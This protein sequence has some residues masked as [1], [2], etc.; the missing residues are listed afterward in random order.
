MSCPRLSLS[1]PRGG[2]AVR[3]GWEEGPW[4]SAFPSARGLVAGRKPGRGAPRAAGWGGWLGGA[5]RISS[6]WLCVKQ[7]GVKGCS[8]PPRSCPEAV[9][10]R[11]DTRLHGGLGCS[12]VLWLQPWLPFV[13]L[14]S[15]DFPLFPPCLLCLSLGAPGRSRSLLSITSHLSPAHPCASIERGRLCDHRAPVPI[16]HLRPFPAGLGCT[17]QQSRGYFYYRITTC[18]YGAPCCRRA[19]HRGSQRAAVLWG[20]CLA[21]H[22]G[23]STGKG[24]LRSFLRAFSS[25]A[26]QGKRAPGRL[27]AA[28]T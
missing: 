8:T 12:S 1:S 6:K 26:L 15:Q 10:V 9:A 22:G 25:G 16:P 3:A 13:L 18:L 28:L 17:G 14:S 27:R 5:G 4:A 20:H 7:G 21:P 23:D 11:G 19:T 2:G 24:V